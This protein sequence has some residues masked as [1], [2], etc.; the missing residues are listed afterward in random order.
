MT[1]ESRLKAVAMKYS[2]SVYKIISK[3]QGKQTV[4]LPA[5]I[6]YSDIKREPDA[7]DPLRLSP[8]TS[9]AIRLL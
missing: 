6:A 1:D 3:N 2:F 5:L 4:D 7:S 9:A 8:Q